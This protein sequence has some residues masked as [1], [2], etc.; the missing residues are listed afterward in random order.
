MFTD[1]LLTG[2]YD[3]R[4]CTFDATALLLSSLLKYML[5]DNQIFFV[6]FS[7]LKIHHLEICLH[8]FII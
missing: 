5:H 7:Q 6:T 8:S 3:N 1:N 4:N 2:M